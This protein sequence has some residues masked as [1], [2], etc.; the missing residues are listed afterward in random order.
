MVYL[1]IAGAQVLALPLG[2]IAGKLKNSIL[3]EIYIFLIFCI[4]GT[5]LMNGSISIIFA[6]LLPEIFL[7]STLEAGTCGRTG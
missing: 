4:I 5:L 3:L 2:V 7:P 1:I 6:G